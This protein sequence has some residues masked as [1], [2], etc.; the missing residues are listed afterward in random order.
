MKVDACVD[1]MPTVAAAVAPSPPLSKPKKGRPI[2][3]DREGLPTVC[4]CVRVNSFCSN[5]HTGGA[6]AACYHHLCHHNTVGP[7]EALE[8]K[9]DGPVGGALRQAI[10]RLLPP[11]HCVDRT[12]TRHNLHTT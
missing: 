6:S 1:K 10:I 11:P 4:V 3:T 9:P 12:P 7:L 8:W 5:M 2:N